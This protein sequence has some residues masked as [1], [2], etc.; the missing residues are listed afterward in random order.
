[1]R[2]WRVWLTLVL[3]SV[4]SLVMVAAP[5]APE[6]GVNTADLDRSCAPCTD[7][8][9]F[10]NGGWMAK[11]PI[12]PAYP[13]WGVMDEVTDHNREVLHQILEDAAKDTAAP[14]GSSEQKI[15]DY[16]GSC[17]DTA[18]IDSEDLKPLQPELDRIQK[19][20]NVSDLEAEISHLQSIGV[21]A[22]F[23]VGSMQDFKDSSQVTGG[24]D[25]GGLGMPDR[26]YYTRD[27]P[28]SKEQRAEYLK[29]VSKM[30]ELMGDPAATAATEAQTVMDLET[31][32]AK[33][34]QTRVE[35]RDPKNIYHRMP[36]SALKALAPSFPWEDYFTAVS[37]AGKGDVN[38]TA[39][40]F[41]KE[42][43]QMISVQPISN[44]KVYIR[45]HLINAAAPSLSTPFV[46]EDFHFKGMILT[47][48][49]EIL[50]RWKRCV[51]STDRA[52]G[53]ALGQVYVKK[54]FP[55]EAK[56]RAL[57]M[58][59]NLE[60]ALADDI[61]T[62]PWMSEATRKQALI[63]LAAINNKIGYPDK[64][65]DYSALDVDRGPYVENVF[66]A[67]TFEFRFLSRNCGSIPAPE[68]GP[69]YDKG[70]FPWH[71]RCENRKN[72]W[73]PHEVCC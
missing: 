27:D 54:A 53:E 9:Q 4:L 41:F 7:F 59:K 24:V 60:A 26:D 49:K 39:P 38:V 43:G 52:L 23:D 47:G 55:P 10:A 45:W 14:R 16:Y 67:E 11:N 34:S 73:S 69:R 32:L 62:L 2:S 37:L 66:R 22:F 51:Q 8:N 35:Q 31:Q 57:A 68:A 13:R 3:L 21:G 1:M 6:H 56:T 42:M 30:F 48:A 25:Q 44:W 70:R 28:K 29:H 40:G 17:M 61:K 15:G 36:Q 64:W 12:P 63:K 72:V 58:V 71:R 19:I 46:D 33:A 65:R 20:A 18:K 50:P 5:L